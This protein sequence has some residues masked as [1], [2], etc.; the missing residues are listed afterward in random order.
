MAIKI[1]IGVLRVKQGQLQDLHPSSDMSCL[2]QWSQGKM[3][4][5]HLPGR[6]LTSFPMQFWHQ[7]AF[8]VHTTPSLFSTR[9]INFSSKGFQHLYIFKP[10]YCSKQC[11]KTVCTKRCPL[12]PSARQCLSWLSHVLSHYEPA[13][14]ASCAPSTC[15]CMGCSELFYCCKSSP[16]PWRAAFGRIWTKLDDWLRA[17]LCACPMPG[18]CTEPMPSNSSSLPECYRQSHA[19]S[20]SDK[21]LRIAFQPT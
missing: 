14:P 2:E 11:L 7:Q 10:F 17:S 12:F 13:A 9:S 20:V 19:L 1:F 21:G 15:P 4:N 16:Y 8:P 18:S 5:S 6:G 3:Q